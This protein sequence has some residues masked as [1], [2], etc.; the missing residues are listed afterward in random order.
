MNNY[1]WQERVDCLLASG[2]ETGNIKTINDND[3]ISAISLLEYAAIQDPKLLLNKIFL[4]KSHNMAGLAMAALF[5]NA[6]TDFFNDPDTSYYIFETF[7]HKDP[8]QL[9]E[10]VEYLKS[11]IFIKGFGSRPQKLIRKIMEGWTI[12]IINKYV[13]TYSKQLHA[14]LKLVHPRY[15]QE[16]GNVIKSF[17]RSHS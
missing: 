2:N 16:R 10:V 9:L 3:V 13:A 8:E 12:D 15:K 6:S 14:L 1:N 5:A 7:V 11:K 17:L 4:S